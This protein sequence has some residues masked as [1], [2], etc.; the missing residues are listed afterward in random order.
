MIL[1]PEQDTESRRPVWDELQMLYM[2]T[3]PEHL[4]NRMADRL[5]ESPYTTEELEDILWNEVHPACEF[6][7]RFAIAPEW[8]GFDLDWLTARILEKNRFG[9]RRRPWRLRRYTRN[10]WV[11]LLPLI[12]GAWCRQ[13]KKK[14]NKPEMATPNQP[15][16]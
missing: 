14:H 2:D 4:L 7:L 5:A 15:S 3:D 1:S 11:K 6:N 16:D 12:D 13:Q 8:A 10:W 9:R